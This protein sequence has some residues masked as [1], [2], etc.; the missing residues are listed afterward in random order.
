MEKC[1]PPACMH[2]FI[3]FWDNFEF[4]KLKSQY[5]CVGGSSFG[6]VTSWKLEPSMYDISWLVRRAETY[7]KHMP[8]GFDRISS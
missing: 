5:L 4:Y 1:I 6:A 7:W 8:H 2:V 3:L